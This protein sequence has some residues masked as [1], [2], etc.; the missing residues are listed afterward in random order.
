MRQLLHVVHHAIDVPLR[1]EFALAYERKAVETSV[2]AQ[3]AEHWLNRC[4]AP[5]HRL[6]HLRL[7]STWRS[8]AS[9]LPK[10]R[11]LALSLRV[12]HA[13]HQAIGNR[14]RRGLGRQLLR[15]TSTLIPRTRPCHRAHQIMGAA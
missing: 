6:H 1:F 12:Q 14:A 7:K 4:D 8:I 5:W 11:R 15:I 2:V 13:P 10:R 3:I 9:G